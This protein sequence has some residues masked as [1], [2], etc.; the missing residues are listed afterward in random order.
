MVGTDWTPPP[1]PTS[2]PPPPPSHYVQHSVL[3]FASGRFSQIVHIL[4]CPVHYHYILVVH[5]HY[6]LCHN[7]ELVVGTNWTHPCPR[8]VDQH[9][10]AGEVGAGA[11]DSHRPPLPPLHTTRIHTSPGPAAIA[12][13][14]KS[15]KHTTITLIF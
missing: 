9:G 7:H 2:P 8:H 12:N 13:A 10:K 3:L 6:I 11:G 14:T 5:Y 15:Q 4:E 1:H